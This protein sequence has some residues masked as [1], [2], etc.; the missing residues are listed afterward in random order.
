[1]GLFLG[2]SIMTIV[3]LLDFCA[4]KI[5]KCCRKKKRQ[6]S[7]TGDEIEAM[8]AAQLDKR[9]ASAA[10]MNDAFPIP[11]PVQTAS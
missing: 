9:Y 1:M 4:I 3:E 11:R 10:D 7:S 6:R 5:A 8:K 2:A